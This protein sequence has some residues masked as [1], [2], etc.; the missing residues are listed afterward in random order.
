[1]L[2]KI[3]LMYAELDDV[4][5]RFTL[6]WKNHATQTTTVGYI[7]RSNLQITGLGSLGNESNA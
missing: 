3:I 7:V 2:H 5:F 4:R 6:L 1:M